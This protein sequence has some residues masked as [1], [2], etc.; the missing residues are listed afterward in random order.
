V[1][2]VHDL[3]P[4]RLPHLVP[5]RHRWAVRALLGGALRRAAR[6]IAVSETT[7]AEVLA[8]Y[9]LPP[10]RVVVVPEAAAPH[11]APPPPPPPPPTR[12]RARRR[13]SRRPAR[14][15]GSP[16]RTSCSWGTS[17]RRRIS[18]SYWMRS[19]GCDA[20]ASGG[21][22]SSSS[23]VRPAGARIRCREPTRLG[24]TAR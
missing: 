4:L 24:S 9:C 14:D 18:T 3:V 20:R 19:A 11:F 16:V 15:T 6:V 17:S 21:T 1:T 8:R 7:R 22:S 2:T 13:R 10:T 12:R 23:W 5:P